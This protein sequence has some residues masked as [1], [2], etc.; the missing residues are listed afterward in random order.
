MLSLVNLDSF[1]SPCTAIPD[2]Q[3]EDERASRDDIDHYIFL[4]PR[5]DWCSIFDEEA[6]YQF[7]KGNDESEEE[8]DGEDY[9]D[10][11]SEQGETVDEEEGGDDEEEGS[12]DD[13]DGDECIQEDDD[14]SEDGTLGDDDGWEGVL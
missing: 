8:E 3:T 13:N 7:Y 12:D 11:N 6:E 1:E 14:L 10:H 2:P 4:V 9:W 5:D